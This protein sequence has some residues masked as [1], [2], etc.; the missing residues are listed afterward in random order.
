M[1]W[2]SAA[3]YE[4]LPNLK[5]NWSIIGHQGPNMSR[6]CLST[7]RAQYLNKSSDK[8]WSTLF[9]INFNSI[10]KTLIL[11]VMLLSMNCYWW[12]LNYNDNDQRRSLNVAQFHFQCCP[13]SMTSRVPQFPGLLKLSSCFDGITVIAMILQ[14]WDTVNNVT[15]GVKKKENKLAKLG[16]C[17][18]QKH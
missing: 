9:S 1:W 11:F 16:R 17:D 8:N 14:K 6:R 18:G 2:C 13:I 15:Q 12:C 3:K 10:H 4:V 7:R 5:H